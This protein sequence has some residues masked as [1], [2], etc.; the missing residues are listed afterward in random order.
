MIAQAWSLYISFQ[1]GTAEEPS[2]CKSVR[3]LRA[4]K[5]IALGLACVLLAWSGPDTRLYLIWPQEETRGGWR[6][7][8]QTL[9]PEGPLG[10]KAF[11]VSTCG[12]FPAF[13]FF[14]LRGRSDKRREKEVGSFDGCVAAFFCLLAWSENYF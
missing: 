7:R 10:T 6:R 4:Y 5:D 3:L 12:R 2:L 14:Y 11:T 1:I 13:L 9:N 8:S